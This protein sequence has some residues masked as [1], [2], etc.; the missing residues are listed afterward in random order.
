[1]IAGVL[2]R[3]ERGGGDVASG[4]VGDGIP[5][6]L[7]QEHDVLAFGDPLSTEPDAHAATQRLGEQQSLG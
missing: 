5:S 4:E 1:M 6:R 2:A 3:L 7:V